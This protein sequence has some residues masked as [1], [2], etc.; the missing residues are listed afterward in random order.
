MEIGAVAWLAC[1]WFGLNWCV[2]IW[3]ALVVFTTKKV[4]GLTF[5][6]ARVLV[7]AP[8]DEPGF[9][10]AYQNYKK[11]KKELRFVWEG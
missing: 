7:R 6:F 4:G 10:T 8:I 9:R 1:A 3:I 2:I 5:N 11:K